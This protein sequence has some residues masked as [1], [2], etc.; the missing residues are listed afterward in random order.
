[1]APILAAGHPRRAGREALLAAARR[2]RRH[3]ADQGQMRIGCYRHA[4]LAS[5]SAA[6]ACFQARRRCG[7]P[8]RL[9]GAAGRH[10]TRSVSP[11][12]S[13]GFRAPAI[14]GGPGGV[15]PRTP[16][17]RD[18]PRS[19]DQRDAHA[20]GRHPGRGHWAD[21]RDIRRHGRGAWP[22]ASSWPARRPSRRKRRSRT[23]VPKW[24]TCSGGWPA[25]GRG[26]GR[27]PVG[28][29]LGGLGRIPVRR[30]VDRRGSGRRADL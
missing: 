10:I 25:G 29:R 26:S 19:A 24:P 11:E 1:M 16:P 30:R 27:L 4:R 28:L 7:T 23:C 3:R 12:R 6:A 5:L 18:H 22:P 14:P 20:V 9:A 2:P 17:G 13:P 8:P 21:R 15:V